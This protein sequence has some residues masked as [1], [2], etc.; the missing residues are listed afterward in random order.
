MIAP[1]FSETPSAP[2]TT[3]PPLRPWFLRSLS[4][5]SSTRNHRPR[6]HDVYLEISVANAFDSRFFND[7][8]WRFRFIKTGKT[9]IIFILRFGQRLD[10]LEILTKILSPISIEIGL[11]NGENGT[12]VCQIRAK[13]SWWSAAILSD[14]WKYVNRLISIIRGFV[15]HFIEQ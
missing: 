4:H 10:W 5:S 11:K 14:G 13:V 6:F 1:L 9:K 3:L 2:I 15:I 7:I 12:K 8:K